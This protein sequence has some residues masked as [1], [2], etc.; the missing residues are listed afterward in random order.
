MSQRLIL[1]LAALALGGC[2]H[3]A[4]E[5]GERFYA[6]MAPRVAVFETQP[7]R[8]RAIALARAALEL[9]LKDAESARYKWGEMRKA[10]RGD[11]S[12]GVYG[13]ALVVLVNAKNSFGAY[14]GYQSH[15]IFIEADSA[16]DIT[17]EITARR[18]RILCRK[19]FQLLPAPLC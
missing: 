8:E 7:K 13:W 2:A 14:T 12:T 19:S 15:Y 11:F 18:A 16:V 1:T 4:R 17:D 9:S 3:D 10:H 6:S 5:E